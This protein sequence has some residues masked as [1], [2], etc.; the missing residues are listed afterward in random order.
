M[1]FAEDSS[2]GIDESNSEDAAVLKFQ[3][4]WNAD[5]FMGVGARIEI[6][7]AFNPVQAGN[8]KAGTFDNA[9]EPAK[10]IAYLAERYVIGRQFTDTRAFLDQLH[11]R[12]TIYHFR[13]CNVKA[14]RER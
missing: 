12:P 10:V 11:H 6:D 9:L 5:P 2:V 13:P 1:P 3:P 4:Q 7:R 8:R 14:V